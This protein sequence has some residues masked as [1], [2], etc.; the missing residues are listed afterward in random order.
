MR[1]G[2]KVDEL[3]VLIKRDRFAGGNVG[4][5]AELVAFLFSLA[6]LLYITELN[7]QIIA[8][9]VAGAFCLLISYIA[10]ER[11]NSESARALSALGAYF[12]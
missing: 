5:T 6:A 4:E 7:D 2:A 1:A 3:A 9:I 11:P 12:S 8:S 10:S